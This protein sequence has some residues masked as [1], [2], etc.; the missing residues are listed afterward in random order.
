MVETVRGQHQIVFALDEGK[1]F[2]FLLGSEAALEFELSR[3]RKDGGGR[4][5]LFSCLRMGG[6]K[7]A[8]DIS[9]PHWQVPV[10]GKFAE[11]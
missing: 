4:G 6:G 11:V 2:P 9:T 1:E 10:E 5:G 8:K 3:T 7:G